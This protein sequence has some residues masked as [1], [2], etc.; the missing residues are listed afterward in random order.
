VQFNRVLSDATK[1]AAILDMYR[2]FFVEI[3]NFASSVSKFSIMRSLDHLL[4]KMR[5]VPG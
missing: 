2:N 5:A 1:I 4:R 3:V